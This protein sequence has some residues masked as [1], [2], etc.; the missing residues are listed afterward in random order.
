MNPSLI[1]GSL[2][3][4]SYSTILTK[5]VDLEPKSQ[6]SIRHTTKA[7]ALAAEKADKTVRTWQ[8]QVPIKYH[9][10]GAVFSKKASQRF[11]G[12][13]PWDHAINLVEN[14]PELLNCKTTPFMKDNKNC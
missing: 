10:Y 7:T 13:R 6:T 11:P 3:E 12:P 14:A 9:R 5:Y 2:Q 8:E 1:K 4:S